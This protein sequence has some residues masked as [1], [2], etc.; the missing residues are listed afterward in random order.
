MEG[1]DEEEMKTDEQGMRKTWMVPKG[2]TGI[3][4][5]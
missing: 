5:K 1:V 4:R 3:A 2:K